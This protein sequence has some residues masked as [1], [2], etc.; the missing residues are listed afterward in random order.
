[1]W[2]TLQSVFPDGVCDWSQPGRGQGPAETWLRYD[3]RDGGARYGGRN[4]GAVPP[5]SAGGLTSPVF[6]SMLRR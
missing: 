1:Q 5:H 2:S 3:A 4:L 6:A